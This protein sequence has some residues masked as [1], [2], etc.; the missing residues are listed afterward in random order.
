MACAPAG[1]RCLFSALDGHT[2]A[3]PSSAG[4]SAWPTS[5]TLQLKS[6]RAARLLRHCARAPEEP[7]EVRGG[8][9]GWLEALRV[10]RHADPVR[11]FPPR[12]LRL[13]HVR[14]H[15]SRATLPRSPALWH[16]ASLALGTSVSSQNAQYE[17]QDLCCLTKFVFIP[18]WRLL[19]LLPVQCPLCPHQTLCELD[20]EVN[21]LW[22]PPAMPKTT[23][24]VTEEHGDAGQR[25]N[26]SNISTE[27]DGVMESDTGWQRPL[28]ERISMKGFL[29]ATRCQ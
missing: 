25:Q 24:A 16:S 13:S 7:G 12:L 18:H 6:L 5:A 14:L 9:L 15:R 23:L 20:P 22:V 4:R 2:R 8:S 11:D 17:R 1:R 28:G 3:R 19:H 21:G 26:Q 10:L 29:A 27:T